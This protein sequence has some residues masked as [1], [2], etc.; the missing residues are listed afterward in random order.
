MTIA[1][2]QQP[3]NAG[4]I[5]H[6]QDVIVFCTKERLMLLDQMNLMDHIIQ[7]PSSYDYTAPTTPA[8]VVKAFKGYQADLEIVA[9]AAS[10]TMNDVNK[11]AMPEEFAAQTGKTYGQGVP[12][13]PMPTM[14]KGMEDALAA[15]GRVYAAT[16][17][18]LT[19]LRD[20][21][22]DGAERLGFDTGVA[23]MHANTLWGPGA[24]EHMKSLDG[25]GPLG[26][27]MASDYCL[28]RNN[29][30]T[31]ALKGAAIANADPQVLAARNKQPVGVDQLGF[32]VASALYGDPKLGSQGSTLMG[33]GSDAIRAS[34]MGGQ[35][36]F[37]ASFAFHTARHYTR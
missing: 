14:A 32:D 13:S 30:S 22:P 34:L 3:A 2:G 29:N 1:A 24:E 21:V 9:G 5:M 12:P 37:D 17:P 27:R 20:S 6:A 23:I 11:A 33:P 8:D 31:W 16:D 15:Q 36:G 7:N 19:A 4:D 35:G 26:F 28:A 18:L 10:Q 25:G